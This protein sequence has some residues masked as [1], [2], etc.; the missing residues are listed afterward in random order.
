MNEEIKEILEVA[1]KDNII[2]KGTAKPI[3]SEPGIMYILKCNTCTIKA[4]KDKNKV[5]SIIKQ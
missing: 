4:V 3:W 5:W 1:I 2:C